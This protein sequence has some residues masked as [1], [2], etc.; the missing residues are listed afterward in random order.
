[1]DFHASQYNKE[2]GKTFTEGMIDT[3]L[4]VVN[5]DFVQVDCKGHPGYSSY[6]TKVGNQAG[7]YTKDILK[8]WCE[9]TANHNVALYVHYSRIM[10]GKAIG[11]HPNGRVSRLTENQTPGRA[12]YFGP[13]S[14]KLLIQV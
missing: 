12:A 10:D 7:G 2:I 9:V 5:P 1:M 3:F 4:T 11:D 6:P 13:Y 14:D 8:I